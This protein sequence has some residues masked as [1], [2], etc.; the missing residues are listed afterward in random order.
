M[1]PMKIT[2]RGFVFGQST[3]LFTEVIEGSIQEIDITSV[4]ERH[5]IEHDLVNRPHVIEIEFPAV[6]S[7]PASYFRIGTDARLMKIP[8]PLHSL[9]HEGLQ[10]I[11]KRQDAAARAHLN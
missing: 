7:A 8:L 9:E 10:E 3:P 11:L 2:I 6:N 1:V 4:A 5:A